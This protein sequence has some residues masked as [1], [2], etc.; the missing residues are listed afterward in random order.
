MLQLLFKC[1]CFYC[2]V[3]WAEGTEAKFFLHACFLFG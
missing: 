1:S 2:F 3:A